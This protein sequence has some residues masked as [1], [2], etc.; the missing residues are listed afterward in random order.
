MGKKP[1]TPAVMGAPRKEIDFDLLDKYCGY[2]YSLLTCAHFL[3]MSGD[4]V[5]RRIKEKTGKTFAEYKEPHLEGL[6][7]KI[8]QAGLDEAVNKRNTVILKMYLQKYCNF[9]DQ[10]RQTN[11][12]DLSTEA[13]ALTEELKRLIGKK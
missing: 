12:D 10:V 13:K 2:D 6:K 11:V 5:E 4:T 3:G 8:S 9:S 1:T 7:G